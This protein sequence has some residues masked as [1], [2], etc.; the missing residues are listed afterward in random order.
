VSGGLAG[1][2]SRTATAPLDRIKTI[3]QASTSAAS[4]G[5]LVSGLR[6]IYADG[7]LKAFYRGNGTNVLKIA[8]ETGIKFFAFDKF[9]A[10]VISDPSN[11]TVSERFLAGG[12]AGATSQVAIY[13]LEIAKTRLALSSPGTYRGP[14]DCMAQIV[15][16]EGAA[17]LYTGLGTSV[18]GI[19]PYAGVDLAINSMLKEFASKY[20]TQRMQ[21]P[22]IATLLAC[23]MLSSSCAMTVTYPV[24]LVRTRLQASGMPGAPK[25]DGGLDC[26]RQIISK[27]GFKGL[28]RG[29]VPNAMKVLPATSISYAMYDKLCS[30]T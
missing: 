11:P 1:M 17:A 22:G 30:L 8:P 3:M 16:K 25:Y 28:Y 12:L 18:L 19:I 29:M 26:L 9:K 13:P 27:D 10:A 7:G 21:E 23:G 14:M 15:R 24:G 5:G 2:V 4:E 6:G 20:Y